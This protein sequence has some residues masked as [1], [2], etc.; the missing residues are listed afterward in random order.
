MK[1]EGPM[2]WRIFV[3]SFMAI[4]LGAGCKSKKVDEQRYK[5]M[6][7]GLDNFSSLEE[8]ATGY[9]ARMG[10]LQSK[11]KAIKEFNPKPME[12]ANLDM[13]NIKLDSLER[14][15]AILKDGRAAI[16]RGANRKKV[17]KE[18]FAL[19]VQNKYR[20]FHASKAAMESAIKFN[21]RLLR[22]H[23]RLDKLQRKFIVVAKLAIDWYKHVQN[24]LPYQASWKGWT[25]YVL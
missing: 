1:T 6:R 16:K 25:I 21:K 12:H 24:E 4:L 20:E 10:K 8:E 9:S 15:L 14:E 17:G 19:L 18:V 23:G 22:V 13:L 5:L 11:L 2:I 7:K 3:V